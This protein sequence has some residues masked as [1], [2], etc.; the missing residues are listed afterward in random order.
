MSI[1]M[2]TESVE[3]VWFA[4]TFCLALFLIM[5]RRAM[6]R[7]V[8]RSLGSFL[9]D[10][11]GASYALPYV[12]TLPFLMVIVCCLIQ[13][14]L[15]LL[16]KFGTIHAGYGAAR[17]AIVW[18]GSDPDSAGESRNHAE[19]YADRAAIIGMTPFSAGINM[20]RV[21]RMLMFTYPSAGGMSRLDRE[22]FLQTEGRLYEPM[23]R[24]LAALGESGDPS[25][26]IL[27]ADQLSRDS[28]IDQKLRVAAIC[29]DAKILSGDDIIGFNDDV[30]VEV[31]Y[32]MPLQ[33]P[34]A[35]HIFDN[36]PL[37]GWFGSDRYYSRTITTTVTLP[38]EA[39]KTDSRRLEVPYFPSEI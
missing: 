16:A 12:M 11:S 18:Q 31:S 36:D 14:T 32:K 26:V 25:P 24:R 20:A 30:S 9:G 7:S 29:T 6:Q 13:G 10:E 22:A 8:W 4:W 39:A 3:W 38:S 35:A 1:S 17:A 28:Y 37:A 34:L 15:I 2:L 33:V 23:Y 5:T 21:D 19:H 27:N